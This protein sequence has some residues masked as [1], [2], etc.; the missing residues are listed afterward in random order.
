MLVVLT[1][2]EQWF[3]H[4]EAQSVGVR[5]VNIWAALQTYILRACVRTLRDEQTGWNGVAEWD[6]FGACETASLSVR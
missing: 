4:H 6:T 3:F 5:N 1:V 2:P